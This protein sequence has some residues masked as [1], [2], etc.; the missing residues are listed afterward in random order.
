[1]IQ[2][3]RPHLFRAF[4]LL[5][6]A[7][8]LSLC[9]PVVAAEK[10]MLAIGI[11]RYAHL[12]RLHK[13]EN[14]ARDMAALFSRTGNYRVE[15]VLLGASAD[16]NGMLDALRRAAA[17]AGR[18][19]EL[20]VF[21]SGHGVQ[22][23]QTNYLLPYDLQAV[24]EGELQDRAVPLQRLLD[25]IHNSGIALSMV[26][27]DACRNNPLA[28]A[29]GKSVG[30]SKG[31]APTTPLRGQVLAYAAG[32]GEEALDWLRS[33]DESERNSVF[34]RVLLKH[35]AT[36]GLPVL[37][38]LTITRDEVEE[39]ARRERRHS[40]RPGLYE[41]LRRSD[42]QR[43]VLFASQNRTVANAPPAVEQG[44]ELP[45]ADAAT[46]ARQATRVGQRETPAAVI[47]E[48]KEAEPVKATDASPPAAEPVTVLSRLQSWLASA[49]SSGATPSQAGTGPSRPVAPVA[50][51]PEP[52]RPTG[53]RVGD[54]FR[55]CAECPEMVVLPAGSFEM[56]DLHGDGDSDEKPV[57]T[58]RIGQPFAMG[59]Y[60][61]TYGQWKKVMGDGYPEG[62][63]S[64]DGDED[65]P[66]V[67]VSW[68][69]AQTFVRKLNRITGKNY[70]LPSE[71]EF[72][73]ALRA[74]GRAKWPW[75]DDASGACGYANVAD[76][77]A[78]R[79]YPDLS[80]H[81]CDDGNVHTAPVGRYKANAFGLHD[82][83]GNVWEWVQD[84]YE[85]N[86]DKGQPLDGRAYE[87]VRNCESGVIRGGGWNGNSRV[88]RSAD[89]NWH[90]PGYRDSNLGFR[91]SRTLP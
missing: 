66:V 88:T 18:D 82:V 56:G 52:A 22:V 79:Q 29:G 80:I 28:T 61:V 72:E 46:K 12:Q 50:A 81:D 48:R 30:G 49:P 90:W 11:D 54:T 19:G 5:H 33:P 8:V 53:P 77:S 43:F 57:R 83:S 26:I 76:R 44:S 10:V 1:M 37:D 38:A 36:P 2:F 16:R 58:V 41:D 34:T 75:G 47:E 9:M 3:T 40:Q 35:L 31:L 42:K 78:K 63:K 14:D 23:G 71:A 4:I 6:L 67:F 62:L 74:G 89:R 84:C 69:A 15:P 60:E 55:D 85:Y 64:C 20:V 32:N 45:A 7:G 91:L 24:S 51:A 87:P 73:Y 65:C 86:Y 21:F 70:R 59:K 27:L 25:E 13:A 68:S 39:L 17:R